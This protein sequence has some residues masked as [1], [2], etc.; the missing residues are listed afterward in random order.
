[1]LVV[2]H[3]HAVEAHAVRLQTVEQL[4]IDNRNFV[5][6]HINFAILSARC[7]NEI[8]VE[9]RFDETKTPTNWL[10]ASTFQTLQVRSLPPAVTTLGFCST[11]KSVTQ[12]KWPNIVSKHG[13]C[14][15][16]H[17]WEYF[18]MGEWN[19]FLLQRKYHLKKNCACIFLFEIFV[20]AYL[21]S[22][23]LHL[24][25][26]MKR[27]RFNLNSLVLACREEICGQLLKAEGSD[28]IAMAVQITKVFQSWEVPNLE[29][30]NKRNSKGRI[31]SN[32]DE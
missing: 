10:S 3:G 21:S 9:E 22:Q 23:I 7:K 5:I 30:N 11:A 13:V 26:S 2:Y 12:S 14:S 19:N 4:K 17:I 15:T 1:M 32:I 25:F 6:R 24:K 8:L 29:N 28:R 31:S 27:R 16:S 20:F 18:F